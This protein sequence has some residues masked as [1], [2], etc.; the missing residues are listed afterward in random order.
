MCGSYCARGDKKLDVFDVI[1]FRC[2]WWRSHPR[3]WFSM[4]CGNCPQGAYL[5][6]IIR[7]DEEAPMAAAHLLCNCFIFI[8]FSQMR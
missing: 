8:H 3:P 1:A 2:S 4:S 5:I 7:L 6:D